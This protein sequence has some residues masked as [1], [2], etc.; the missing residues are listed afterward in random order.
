M[1]LRT[2]QPMNKGRY[3]YPG[4]IPTGELDGQDDEDAQPPLLR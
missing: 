4:D 3:G 1:N 2:L